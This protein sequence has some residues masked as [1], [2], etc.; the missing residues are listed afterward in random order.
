VVDGSR[1]IAI[2][3]VL[4]GLLVC[5]ISVA[6]ETGAALKRISKSLK[7]IRGIVA[8][9]EYSEIV[10]KRAIEGRGKLYVEF[11]G[12]VR[13]EVGG[14]DPRTV[15]FT[16]PYLY[17][18]RDSDQ[19]VDFYDVTSN[20]HR[21]GQYILLGFVPAGSA[22]KKRYRVELVPNAKL[23]DR[24]VTSFLLTPK[25]EEAASA[26]ARIQLWVDPESGLPLQHQVFHALSQT[27]L[28]VRYLSTTR[29]D[30]LPPELFRPAWPAGTTILRR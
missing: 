26:I 19:V 8:K 12:Q 2:P 22:M 13:V 6:D 20:P 4:F 3:W 28:V 14:D 25:D 11:L 29:D 10:D 27:S 24:P 30:E 21:L 16:P 23:D 18:H 15:L 5:T 7:G 9:V 1:K 17:I